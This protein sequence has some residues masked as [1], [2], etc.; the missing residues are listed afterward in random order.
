MTGGRDDEPTDPL[1]KRRR[2]APNPRPPDDL[3]DTFIIA[4][5]SFLMGV[6]FTLLAIYFFDCK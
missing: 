5:A 2:P 3:G 6:G 4:L 1:P